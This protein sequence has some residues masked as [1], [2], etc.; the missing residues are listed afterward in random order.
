LGARSIDQR[1]AVIYHPQKADL[2]RLRLA[3]ERTLL[4]SGESWG[5]TIWLETSEVDQGSEQ[6]RLAIDNGA[7][8]LLVVGG[9]GTLRSVF[10]GSIDQFTPNGS[11]ITLGLVPAGTGN[12]LARNLNLPLLNLQNLVRR[13]ILGET[14][15][16]DGARAIL[17]YP[18]GETS[19]HVFTMMA[20]VGLDASIVENAD[21]KLKSRIGWLAYF[22]AG[23]KALPLKYELLEIRVDDKPV[24]HKRVLT[25]L[26]GNVG[27]LPMKMAVMPAAKLDDGLLD[28]AAIA[29]RR[30]W[31]WAHLWSRITFESW[32]LGS[33]S[34]GR[35]LLE[36]T[37]DIKT[38]E[39]LS[40]RVIDISVERPVQVQIDGDSFGQV[41]H[42]RFEV[43]EKKLH[44]RF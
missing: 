43:L 41:T 20:G 9:D 36:N 15:A 23:I 10:E 18:K 2:R 14:T 39:N 42:M 16:L 4:E 31:H 38:L 37:K 6:A 7:T 11:P 21:P 44:L 29:P 30:F 13:G 8:Q 27:L 3:V 22:D 28:V 26:V 34:T 12:I 1:L 5:P 25:L 24:I 32:I 17:T 33:S 19:Q 35:W 40:G